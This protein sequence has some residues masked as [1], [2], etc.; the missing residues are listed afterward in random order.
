MTEFLV[1]KRQIILGFKR[2]IW[3]VFGVLL[4]QILEMNEGGGIFNP[5]HFLFCVKTFA[6]CFD[7]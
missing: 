2:D 3:S 7:G 6:D 4:R 5:P 1:F